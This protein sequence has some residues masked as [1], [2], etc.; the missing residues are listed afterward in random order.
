[1]YDAVQ[2][3]QY[4]ILSACLPSTSGCLWPGWRSHAPLAN[5]ER[6]L[7]GSPES[8]G[9][10]G[11][12]TI[13]S[14]SELSPVVSGARRSS[15]RSSLHVVPMGFSRRKNQRPFVKTPPRPR[16]LNWC[17]CHPAGV[18]TTCTASGDEGRRGPLG[19]ERQRPRV[20]AG[21]PGT[22]PRRLGPRQAEGVSKKGERGVSA[23]RGNRY[24]GRAWMIELMRFCGACLWGRVQQ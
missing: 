2:R 21:T 13:N 12:R 11:A 22:R 8:S 23:H 16:L 1:M 3:A 14:P 9:G 4:H 15:D 24:R 19:R 18:S 20:F 7:Y 17:R 10:V 6:M 5:F